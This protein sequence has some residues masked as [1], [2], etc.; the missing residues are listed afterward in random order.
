MSVPTLEAF[1]NNLDNHLADMLRL[2]S[3]AEDVAGL[4]GLVG[5]VG[6]FQLNF[7]MISMILLS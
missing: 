6:P 1:K 4:D 2:Y 5:L 3:C 7:S